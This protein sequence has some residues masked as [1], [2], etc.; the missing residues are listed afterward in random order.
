MMDTSEHLLDDQRPNNLE[1]QT[2]GASRAVTYVTDNSAT[3]HHRE[4]R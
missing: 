1:L 3:Y 4:A 2:K